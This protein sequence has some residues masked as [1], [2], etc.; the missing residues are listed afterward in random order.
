[1]GTQE[2]GWKFERIV[3]VDPVADH[4]HA[5]TMSIHGSGA[6]HLSISVGIQRAPTSRWLTRILNSSRPRA[7]P[8]YNTIEH[9]I[10]LYLTSRALTSTSAFDADARRTNVSFC[11]ETLATLESSEIAD[12]LHILRH[13]PSTLFAAVEMLRDTSTEVYFN[14]LQN[15]YDPYTHTL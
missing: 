3:W 9:F 11:F 1:M 5:S 13:H 6:E 14:K 8:P 12:I 15:P 7:I 4:S 2:G 10:E